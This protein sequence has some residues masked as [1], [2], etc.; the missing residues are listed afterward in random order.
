MRREKR[1]WCAWT[2]VFAA[3]AVLVFCAQEYNPFSDVSNVRAAV[4]MLTFEDGDTVEIFGDDTLDVSIAVAELVDSFSIHCTA[5][6]WF[7]DT[8]IVLW[9]GTVSAAYRFFISLYDTGRQELSIVTW[10]KG[11]VSVTE[12]FMVYAKSPLHQEPIVALYG[13]PLPLATPPV[14]ARDVMYHWDFGRGSLFHSASCRDT[15]VVTDAGFN[16]SGF[17]WVSDVKNLRQSPRRL[18]SFSLSDNAGPLII[19]VNDG[20]VGR[21]T[22]ITGNVTFPLRLSITDRGRG[23]V[24]DF[25]SG[26]VDTVFFQIVDPASALRPVDTLRVF[27]EDRAGHTAEAIV[28]MIFSP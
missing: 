9:G 20:Y 21:D 15:V 8:T 19:C 23:G 13:T 5:N 22:I 6:R 7:A 14:A 2:A 10:R 17:L 3:L 25:T 11:S 12:R 26:G 28:P 18:F 16:D 1:K 4:R 27:V 24:L